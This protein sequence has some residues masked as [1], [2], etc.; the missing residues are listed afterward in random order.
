VVTVEESYG[1]AVIVVR[2]CPIEE[3]LRVESL[4]GSF[5][6]GFSMEN[7]NVALRQLEALSAI[8]VAR[9]LRI[10]RMAVEMAQEEVEEEGEEASW[11]RR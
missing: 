7:L 2:V 5:T 3:E 1:W 4:K 8:K 9:E 10:S 11:G 6:N